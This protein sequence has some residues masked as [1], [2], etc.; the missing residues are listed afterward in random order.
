[1]RDHLE[2]LKA[3]LADR[4]TIERK[5]GAG[6]MATVYLALDLKHDRKVAIKV[7]RPELSAILGGE[8]FLR[9]VSIAAKLN[10]PHILALHDSGQADEFL[11][12]VMPHVE[13]E[14][15][16]AKL[17]R[18]RQLSVD[19]A[20]AI[21]TQVG[22]ALDYAHEQ[23]V[24]HRD[25]KPENIL[26][27]QGEALV[28]DFGIALA[29]TAA[30]G[31]RITDTGLSLGTPEY[32][33]PEQAT[34][35]R[36]LDARSDVYSLGA[37]SYEMLVGEPP[38]TG[39]S[40]QAIIAK[41][42]SAE[43]QPVSRVRHTVPSNVDAAVLCALAK[44]PADRFVS[45]AKFVEALVNPAFAIRTA[46]GL[47]EAT[48][49]QGKR[50]NKL[51]A[52]FAS[53]A[54]VTTLAAVVALLGWLRSPSAGSRVAKRLSIPVADEEA[55]VDFEDR[56]FAISSDGTQ[57][58]YVGMGEI[59]G[60]QLYLRSLDELHATTIGGTQN[61]RAPRFSPDASA[62]A[63]Y[64]GPSGMS[65]MVVSTSGSMPVELVP[66]S[67]Q[68]CLDWGTDGMVYFGSARGSLSRVPAVGGVSE[69][70]TIPDT[71]SGEAAHNAVH[72]LPNG[73]GALFVVWRGQWDTADIAVV[74]F[75]TGEVRILVRGASPQY[76]P[77][78]HLLYVQADSALLAV[79]F[80]QDKMVTTGEPIA[81]AEV[82]ALS[83]DGAAEFAVSNA[84]L[85]LYR[86]PAEN[87]LQLV[88]VGRDGM[89]RVV[90]PEWVGHAIYPTLSPDGT[91]LA[92]VRDGHESRD[93]WIKTLDAGP[94]R[95]L[96]IEGRYNQPPTW[97][98]DGR[99]VTFVSNRGGR[100]LQDIWQ[101]RADGSSPAT[102]L[103]EVDQYTQGVSWSVDG[104]W[105]TYTTRG[106]GGNWDIFAIRPGVDSLPT[107]LMT[108]E[109]SE[110]SPDMS[111]DTRWLTYASDASGRYEVYVRPFPNTADEMWQISSNGGSEP[112]WAHSGRELFYIS[113]DEELVAVE[114]RTEPT[115]GMGSERILFSVADYSLYGWNHNY[116]ISPDDQRFVMIKPI[117]NQSSA[118]M[119]VLNFFEE[120]KER[121]GR[122]HG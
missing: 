94:L 26:I 88:W 68:F 72:V 35:E 8:R 36:E 57:L 52:L 12:Y 47:P 43:P 25:I 83:S 104:R 11:Y 23:G 79:P 34:G 114:I 55:P 14:S 38:H 7:M 62:V 6:G 3:A 110:R 80:D 122:D 18:E 70:L 87:P 86:A 64:G 15:L 39:N 59:D 41:V 37:I 102:L 51:T 42:V 61:A 103:L 21:T 74:D 89:E 60:Q 112:L 32:M 71:A 119:L 106:Q 77:S 2:S 100:R 1:M 22:A 97:T 19:E 95:R 40:V 73:K 10:H 117:T 111:P 46:T 90:D 65:I 31:T 33:S 9:E 93:V 81:L 101:R 116:T 53:I 48:T 17:N 78:G 49:Q 121:F 120:L 4:Y 44:A 29:V 16:R 45:G 82:V 56:D 54:V 115:F 85:L 27:H 24:I 58:V 96:T 50:W 99:S 66:H 30:G 13:G 118:L 5:I 105:L 91:Q 108:S 107:P 98:P 20:I 84:G 67:R 69:V 75:A 28:A 113:G 76:A 92:L 63:Y 109:F